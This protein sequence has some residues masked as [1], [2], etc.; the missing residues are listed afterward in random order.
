[1]ARFRDRTEAGRRL[2]QALE[3]HRA[4]EGV[5]YPL[6]RGGVVLGVEVARSL[7]MPLDLIIPRK[8]GHPSNPEYAIC[9]VTEHGE[10]VCNELERAGVDEEWFKAQVQAARREARRRRELYLGGRA[11]LAVRDRVAI[12]VDDGIAT[13]LT[14]RAAIRDARRRGPATLVVAV[15]VAPA[16]TV[17]LLGREVDEVVALDVPDFYLGAVGAYYMDF[18]Q[19]SDREVMS[20][21]SEGDR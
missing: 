17:A 11:P 14:M 8:I 7:G 9:A 4:E 12:L 19:L 5:V 21:L 13:G 20:L 10:P 6:P 16:E 18:P 1:M 2:A 15:P 3:R